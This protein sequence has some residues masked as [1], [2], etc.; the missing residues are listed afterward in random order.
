MCAA[1]QALQARVDALEKRTGPG[2]LPQAAPAARTSTEILCPPA[3][4]AAAGAA[5]GPTPSPV[6]G[7]IFPGSF[8][9]PGTNTSIGFHGFVDLQTF[10]DPD[11]YLGDKFQVGLIIPNGNLQRQTQGTWHFQ[12]KLTR[13]T[14]ESLTPTKSGDFRTYFSSDFYGYE[15]GGD[16]GPQALQNQNYSLRLREAYGTYHGFLAGKTWSNFEDD[17]DTMDSLDQSGPAGVPAQLV[18]QLRYTRPLKF[19]RL[20]FSAENPATDYADN[21]ASTDVELASPYNPTPDFTGNYNVQ[22]KLGHFQVSGVIRDLAYDDGKGHRSS[23]SAGGGIAGGTINL[24]PK[25]AFG[26]QTWFGDG[27]MKFS[28]DDFGPVS[29]AQINNIGTPQQTLLPSNMHGY[30]LYA[31]HIFSP[32]IRTNFGYGFNFMNWYAFIPADDSQ[33]V[34]TKTTHANIIWSPLPQIDI[35]LE[36]QRG[37]KAFRDSLQLPETFAQRIEGGF[38]YKF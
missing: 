32:V 20:S 17:P 34:T 7:G 23:A 22:S 24:G 10:Y 28:P 21:L 29:S 30:A 37:W 38:K 1:L 11:Q 27:I 26:G 33:P 2:E 25:S 12:G 3:A 16:T 4:P 18:L 36:Y 5:P 19:G 31:L 15:Q 35:G 14:I 8:I 6:V 13:F 9:V